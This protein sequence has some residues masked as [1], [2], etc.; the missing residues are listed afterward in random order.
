MILTLHCFKGN[1]RKRLGKV[2][3][4]LSS[5][6]NVCSVP[7]DEGQL[8][9]QCPFALAYP[10]VQM[11][12]LPSITKLENRDIPTL[13][14]R[15]HHYKFVVEDKQLTTKLSSKVFLN[16]LNSAVLTTDWDIE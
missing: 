16:N 8:S 2:I 13:Q 4:Q 1:V 9:F 3:Q 15:G 12:F 10:H 6:V 7:I 11:T 5:R 14:H